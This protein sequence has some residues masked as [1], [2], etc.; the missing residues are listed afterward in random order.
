MF[1]NRGVTQ[2]IWINPVSITL[3][4]FWTLECTQLTNRS[5]PS[6]DSTPRVEEAPPPNQDA[7]SPSRP[8]CPPIGPLMHP[9]IPFCHWTQEPEPSRLLCLLTI[10]F[11]FDPV[12]VLLYYLA[13]SQYM[14]LRLRV[15]GTP[16]SIYGLGIARSLLP[17]RL[18]SP[19]VLFVPSIRLNNTV[20]PRRWS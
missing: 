7:H 9:Y 2:L 19:F 20:R 6:T 4:K 14:C 12:L 18:I 17:A 10:P 8:F 13:F 5:D 16:K 15:R 11:S 1:W 3:F